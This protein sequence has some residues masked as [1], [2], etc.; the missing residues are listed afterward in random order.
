[1]ARTPK[2]KKD[3]VFEDNIQTINVKS[4]E[5]LD[6]TSLEY[7]MTTL[8]RGIPGIDG[9]KNSQR[10]AIFTLSKISGEIKTVSC[11]G[12]MISDGIYLHGDAS[13]CGTLQQLASPVA[14]NYPLIGKRGGFGTQADSSPA[15]ARYTYVK[16]TK[17]TEDL[18]LCDKD[19]V[20]M[21][22][23]YDGT[24]YEPKHF[25]PIIPLV[26]FGANGISVGYKTTILPHKIEDIVNNCIRA[27][28]GKKQKDMIPYYK[29]NGCN[30][31]VRVDGDNKFTVFGKGEVIDSSTV[32]ITG[33]PINTSLEKFTEKLISMEEAGKI[34]DYDD[35][36]SK[37]VDITIKLPRGTSNGWVE[38]DIIKY[39]DLHSK[40]TQ[41]LIVLGE[42][43][44]VKVYET[45]EALISDFVKF[46]TKYYY[47]RYEK[48]LSDSQKDLKVKSLIKECFDNDI[49]IKLPTMKN[50]MAVVNFITEINKNIG[51][52]EEA[53][54]SI[55]NYP[56]HR[57]T[58]ESYTQLLVD[59]STVNDDIDMY[60]QILNSPEAIRDIY[61]SELKDLLKGNYEPVEKH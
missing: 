39:F 61:I 17:S 1:M 48:L 27:L 32:R 41:S 34:R 3:V 57:W 45:T 7:A 46:R 37:T 23:N 9:L 6:T 11:G 33:L 12:R 24:V 21:Q 10:K 29:S 58:E 8:D 2:V 14:N 52:E 38:D 28:E 4:S 50:R 44:K 26:L 31:N 13:A 43:G 51:A 15:S 53:V 40:V 47:K 60:S 5:Y 25:L 30:D 49:T 36:S 56:I 19:V 16:K 18:V 54:G 22:L 55:A 35:D 42:N 59:I 20:P